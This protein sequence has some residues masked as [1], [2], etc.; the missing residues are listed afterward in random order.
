MFCIFKVSQQF[1]CRPHKF[2]D[3]GNESQTDDLHYWGGR[4]RGS[5]QSRVLVIATSVRTRASNVRDI[6]DLLAS[7]RLKYKM[8]TSA[9]SLPDLSPSKGAPKYLVIVFQDIQDYYHMEAR[10]RET[11]DKYC[12]QF[13]V[14]ILAFVPSGVDKV[15]D[16]DVADKSNN[17]S[18]I[19]TVT[20]QMTLTEAA[21]KNHEMLRTIKQNI[22]FRETRSYA[23]WLKF[24][25]L[26]PR[27]G[28][29]VSGV[30]SDGSKGPIVVEDKDSD[31]T[32]IV[33]G[34][35]HV[36]HFWF[37]KL[38]FIDAL[39][40][41]TRGEV[42]FPLTRYVLVDIDDIFVGAARLVPSDVHAMVKSQEEMTRLVTGF[43]YNLGFSGK[44]FKNGGDEENA[45]DEAMV[46]A[47]GKFWWFPHMWKHIQPHR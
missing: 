32:K 36:L 20:S 42:S 26:S 19:F 9:K 24:R 10:K 35:S 13:K 45:G 31:V 34:G 3:L 21:I 41:L 30:F 14:G 16:V 27:C 46:A 22:S 37:I 33:I 1:L 2:C 44:Y 47:A 39:H 38:V 12:K 15:T 29:V 43:Q 4:G 6:T 7:L 5:A 17:Q 8:V 40:F 28:P 23:N 11:L 18:S 25:C